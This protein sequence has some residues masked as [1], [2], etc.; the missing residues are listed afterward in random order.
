M[1]WWNVEARGNYEGYELEHIYQ[2]RWRPRVPVMDFFCQ[3]ITQNV[4]FEF[5]H[6]G[7]VVGNKRGRKP[8]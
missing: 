5:Y 4:S 3:V 1:N 6:G 7:Q 2:R 8:T